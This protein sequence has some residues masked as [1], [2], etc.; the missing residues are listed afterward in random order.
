MK[1]FVKGLWKL[2][3]LKK[4]EMVSA[5]RLAKVNLDS[6]FLGRQCDQMME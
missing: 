6:L 3:A 2:T 5:T 1:D 4:A